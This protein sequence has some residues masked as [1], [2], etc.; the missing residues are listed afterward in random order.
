MAIVGVYVGIQRPGVD[1]KRYRSISCRR[2]SS[3]RSAMSFRPLCPA[4]VANSRR[5]P[6]SCRPTTRC[7]SIA[8][9]VISDTVMPRRSASC[10]SRESSSSESFTVVRFMVCQHTISP[11]MPWGCEAE[12]HGLHCPTATLNREVSLQR[13]RPLWAVSPSWRLPGAPPRN[14]THLS[15]VV[16]SSRTS[17]SPPLPQTWG[18]GRGGGQPEPWT[19]DLG[20]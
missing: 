11:C 17:P 18:R 3:I 16:P 8:S 13:S 12:A 2:I 19:L 1:Q 4:P 9:R 15:R 5:R 14:K 6:A 10:R 20:L 7:A